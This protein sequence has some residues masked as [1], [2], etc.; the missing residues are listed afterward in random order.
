MTSSGEEREKR[1]RRALPPDGMTRLV[2]IQ[3][4]AA[5]EA[6]KIFKELFGS[7]PAL[8]VADLNTFEAAGEEVLRS[9]AEAG[10]PA[11]DPFIYQERDLHAETGRVETLRSHLEETDAVVLCVG[12]GTLNDLAKLA[13][14][15]VG[16]PYM[17]AAT[18]ASVD[19][20]TAYGASIT[21]RGFKQTFYCPAPLAF[22]ADLEVIARAPEGMNPSGYADL[23]A[24]IPAGADW[25]LADALGAEAVH[26][27][28]WDLVQG[29][30]REWLA[31]PEGVARGDLEALGNLMEGLVFSGL[32][33]QAARS[34]RAASG[35]EHLFSHLWDNQGHTFHGK[36]PS[37]GFKVGIGTLASS[38]SYEK[39]LERDPESLETDPAAI[40]RRWPA[41]E[42]LEARV[43]A[44]FPSPPALTE[45]VLEQSLGKYLG[46][47]ELSFRLERLR[48]EWP[49]LKE[50]LAAQLLPAREI[51]ARLAAARAPS[52]PEEIGISKQRL[53][54]SY[55]LA[56]MIRSR[57][58]ILDI[59][60]EA[61][62]WEECVENLF[63]PGGF[64]AEPTLEKDDS[65]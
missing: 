19:G 21:D 13:S 32:A 53:R 22:L 35:A 47:K 43:R 16:R 29:R 54:E 36:T 8:V 48:R 64:F 27:Q 33:M 60:A 1:I 39:L 5:K 23:L 65:K 57:Y 7:T 9:L 2:K 24:K 52:A 56:R 44:A 59:L 58:T 18:A 25:I 10:C 17:T 49:A 3:P 45:Q 31:D 46:P 41:R 26:P 15:Q 4:G 12:S 51:R 55:G 34:S 38:A 37:H 14:H 62:W 50:K 61:D 6:G 30:L 42:E 28:A 11:R 40:A 63:R 20:F